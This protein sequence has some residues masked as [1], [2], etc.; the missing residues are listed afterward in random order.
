MH[1]IY[2]N[3][4]ARPMFTAYISTHFSHHFLRLWQNTV[5]EKERERRY[6]F[7][8]GEFWFFE[9]LFVLAKSQSNV[10]SYL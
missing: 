9:A 5:L 4:D 1:L 7:P 8:I 6:H 3:A 2:M 10:G